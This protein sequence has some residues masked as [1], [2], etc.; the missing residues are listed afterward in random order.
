MQI[1]DRIPTN[2]CKFPTKEIVRA[3][4]FTFILNFPQNGAF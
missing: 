4:N 2:S 3:Q 1:L